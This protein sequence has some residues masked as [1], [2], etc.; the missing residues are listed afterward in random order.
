MGPVVGWRE[1]RHV[2]GDAAEGSMGPSGAGVLAGHPAVAAA[3]AG[4]GRWTRVHHIPEVTSTNDVALERLQAGEPAGLVVVADAQTAGRGRAGRG[5][6]D[7]V[8][9]SEGPGN[10]AVTA[11]VPVRAQ[12]AGGAVPL[13]AGLAVADAFRAAGASPTL[14]WPNDVLLDDRKACGILVERHDLPAGSVLLIGCGLDLDWRGVSR[15]GEVAGWTS[16]AE[17]LGAAVD[18]G[19][20]LGA[21]LT[22]LDRRLHVLERDPAALLTAY[23]AAC[24]TLDRPVRVV[25][26]GGEERT[27]VARDL[28]AD[29]HLVV[30]TDDG[31]FVVRAGDVVHL[32]PGT[33]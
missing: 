12:R 21:L 1:E 30:A 15:G 29:G 27:G 19:A 8:Q 3:V 26:P 11:T 6:I 33:I 22:H 2:M 32:R 20:V 25:L 10:L 18:R 31:T 5:W 13:A 24:V 16:L 23:R 14:K 17:S 9:G 4:G 7:A 28:D